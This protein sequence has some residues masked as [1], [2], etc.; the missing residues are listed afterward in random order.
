M[1]EFKQIKDLYMTIAAP[2]KLFIE[3]IR[4]VRN[5]IR[6]SIAR[7]QKFFEVY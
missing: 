3:F 5:N 6:L 1:W 4:E 7:T 2:R